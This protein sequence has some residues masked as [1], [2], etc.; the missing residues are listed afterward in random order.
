MGKMRGWGVGGAG[1]A[2]GQGSRG[3]RYVMRNLLRFGEDREDGGDG[4]SNPV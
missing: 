3:G 4:E 2:E 1:G